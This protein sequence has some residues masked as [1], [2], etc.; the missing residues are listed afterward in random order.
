MTQLF[1]SPRIGAST[2]LSSKVRINRKRKYEVVVQVFISYS[3]GDEQQNRNENI[4][5]AEE[6]VR[7]LLESLGFQ[8]LTFRTNA[9]FGYTEKIITRYIEV[10]K[11]VIGI[12]TKDCKV[13]SD[14]WEPKP[15]ILDEL[16]RAYRNNKNRIIVPIIEE[17]ASLR[18]Y[19]NTIA[20]LDPCY[21]L[22]FKR[23]LNT[24]FNTYGEMLVKLLQGLSKEFRFKANIRTCQR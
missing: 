22:F 9:G 12:F 10:S 7:P 21:K 8:V 6:I 20:L 18:R 19:S 11:V 13:S 24:G 5:M 3:Y 17:G 16:G 14:L 23:D 2:S 15:N 1:E 4:K